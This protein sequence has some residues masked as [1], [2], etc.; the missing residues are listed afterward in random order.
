MIDTLRLTA[1][2]ALGLIERREVS[3]AELHA[4]YLAARASATASCTRTSGSSRTA[5][6][7]ASRSRS[8]T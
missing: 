1:E 2:E 3:S 7:P 8:R 6:A 5:R 4:A